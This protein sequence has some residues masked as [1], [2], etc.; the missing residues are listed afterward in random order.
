MATTSIWAVRKRLDHII[1]YVSNT[2][3]TTQLMSVIDYA[4]NHEKTMEH[5]YVTCINCMQDTP[6]IS[7]KK[8]KE[9]FHDD[10]EIVCFHGYQ[11]FAEGEV[12]PKMAH[13]IGV[14]LAEKLWG[15]C[16]EVVVST[17]LNTDNIHNHFVVNATSFID[18][19][20]YCNTKKDLA[21]LRETSDDLCLQYGLSV[22]ENKQYHAKNQKTYR[23]EVSLRDKIKNDIDMIVATCFT[24][25]QFVNTLKFEGYEIKK[26]NSNIS[27][28]HPTS[29]RYVRLSSLG[30]GYQWNELRNRILQNKVI[31]MRVQTI[32]EKKNYDISPFFHLYKEKKL[33]GLQKKYLQYQYLLGIISKRNN[34]S[35]KYSAELKEAIRHLD[36]ISDQT[37]LL[38]KNHIETFDDLSSYKNDVKCELDALTIKRQ[39]C[40]NRIRRCNN[41][42]IK[43]DYKDEAKS[44]TPRIREL[45]KQI[46]LC[47]GIYKRSKIIVRIDFDR[48]TQGDHRR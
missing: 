2:D 15:D 42:L 31:P 22:V 47:D 13:Q 38:L 41:E 14:E 8:T 39:M 48:Q 12:T 17:H 24:E 18:A 7:M 40:Y 30:E 3:K 16:F 36:E 32:Y 10:K 11:S 43:A 9:N 37:I 46:K 29:E 26:T 35:P 45:R 19:K 25:S 5:Q 33:N 28:K 27:F 6:Y 20:R 1:D 23:L 21:L 34:T 4:T 44:Y